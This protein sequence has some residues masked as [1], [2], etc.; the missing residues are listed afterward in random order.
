MKEKC[1]SWFVLPA[2]AFFLLT[3][4]PVVSAKESFEKA[5]DQNTFKVIS[6]EPL[7]AFE[8]KFKGS[9][10]A[11]GDAAYSISMGNGQSLWLFG[12]SFFGRSKD[13]PRKDCVMPRNAIAVDTTT[14]IDMAKS[15]IF[16]ERQPGYYI[17]KDK[18]HFYWPGD[19]LILKDHLVLF[20]HETKNAPNE[21][22]PFQFKPVSDHCL[23]VQ[24]PQANPKDWRIQDVALK[25]DAGKIQ[26]GIAC[27]LNGPY[28]YI[29]CADTAAGAKSN[30]DKNPT[31][32][33]RL[34]VSDA[35]AGDFAKMKW[36]AQGRWF[37][38][39]E[40]LDLLWPDGASEMSVTKISGLHGYFAF[41][42]PF[43]GKA[44]LM[45]HAE[46]PEGPWSA[47]TPIYRLPA[48]DLNAS[49]VFYYSV[50]AHPQYSSNAGGMRGAKLGNGEIILTYCTNTSNFDR[51]L[52]DKRL[53][54]PRAVKVRLQ[55]SE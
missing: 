21:P 10:F 20:M 36:L 38:K 2:T 1:G 46:R 33:A 24:N 17:P 45:R 42:L 19:G 53:Y 6:T 31:T 48:D 25:N 40:Q 5:A 13:T 32:L 34:N 12:D 51:L 52:K 35:A 15:L 55:I 50:K 16:Y 26:I 39:P 54:F 41:Y 49:D 28:I 23:I 47:S 9:N 43:A 4:A 7:P 3:F 27:I 29:Y 22:P 37:A 18:E 14:D 30:T 11:G 44:I 8:E